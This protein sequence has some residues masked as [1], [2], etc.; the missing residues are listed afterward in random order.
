MGR[1]FAMVLAVL[2]W[3]GVAFGPVVSLGAPG[4]AIAIRGVVQG[5]RSGGIVVRADDGEVYFADLT[6][7]AGRGG[8]ETGDTVKVVGHEGRRPGE[9]IAAFVEPAARAGQQAARDR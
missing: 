3:A 5:E 4:D 1:T 7:A 9:I 6:R 2:V 8:L